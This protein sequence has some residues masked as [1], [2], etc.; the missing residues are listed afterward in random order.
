MINQ[1][2][3]DKLFQFDKL[4][5]IMAYIKSELCMIVK[6]YIVFI[7][8]EDIGSVVKVFFDKIN[9]T[10]ENFEIT[11][12]RITYRYYITLTISKEEYTF[13]FSKYEG[14]SGKFKLVPAIHCRYDN[15]P[16]DTYN[17]IDN[18]H[19]TYKEM[20]EDQSITT[21][22]ALLLLNPGE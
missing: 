16:T 22:A 6:D 13:I 2:V 7:N 19:Y 9:I 14:K 5:E 11:Y 21:Q 17:F 15:K 1:K 10:P 18:Y 3:Y 4:S 20:V 8:S 12:D